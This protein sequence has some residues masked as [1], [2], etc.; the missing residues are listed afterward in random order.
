MAMPV[1][2]INMRIIAKLETY[3]DPAAAFNALRVSLENYFSPG[4]WV[5][6]VVRYK[7]IE[8][9]ARMAPGVLYTQGAYM[10][11]DSETGAAAVPAY[12]LNAVDIPLGNSHTL[13]RLTY[14]GVEFVTDFTTY[15]YDFNALP[16]EPEPR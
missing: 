9:M 1:V 5:G 10:Y 13:P 4:N 14:V 15:T 3:A 6:S 11:R 7:E 8:H 16:F 2:Y 12:L